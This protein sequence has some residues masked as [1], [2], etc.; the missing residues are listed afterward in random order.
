MERRRMDE[1]SIV[2]LFEM[3]LHWRLQEDRPYRGACAAGLST[4]HDGT[5]GAM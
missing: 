5:S 4:G 2:L 1:D 3:L